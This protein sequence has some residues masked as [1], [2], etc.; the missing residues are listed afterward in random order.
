[1]THAVAAAVLANPDSYSLKRVAW[2]YGCAKKGS[3]DEAKLLEVL[4]ARIKGH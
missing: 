2:A 3:D 1:M 4:V